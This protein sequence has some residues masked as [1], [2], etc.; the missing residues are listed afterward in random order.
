MSRYDFNKEH[1]AS[2]YL[3][4]AGRYFFGAWASKNGLWAECAMGALQN[5]VAALGYELRPITTP[6]QDNDTCLARRVAE[7]GPLP[8]T[9]KPGF[10]G[11]D[12]GRMHPINSGAE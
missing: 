8:V 5:A 12:G 9:E 4:D 10:D 7:D 6:Q 11:R 3:G 1:M 2:I